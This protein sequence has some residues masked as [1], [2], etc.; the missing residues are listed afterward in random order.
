[1]DINNLQEELKKVSQIVEENERLK[2]EI[3]YSIE[4]KNK[5]NELIKTIRESHN[6]RESAQCSSSQNAQKPHHFKPF[7]ELS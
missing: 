1:M 3:K 7:N 5:L 6:N 4:H 2:R